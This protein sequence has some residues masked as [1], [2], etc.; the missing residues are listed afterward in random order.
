MVK[1]KQELSE[2]GCIY[3]SLLYPLARAK[4]FDYCITCAVEYGLDKKRQ[5][6]VL[7]LGKTAYQAYS[8]EDALV[9]LKQTNPKR[10]T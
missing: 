7:C 10:T 2:D 4:Y 3:C 1:I 5:F 8:D 9:V 6:A